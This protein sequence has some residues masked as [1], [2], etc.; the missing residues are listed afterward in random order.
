MTSMAL[1]GAIAFS[2]FALV[3]AVFLA[4]CWF[5][6]LYGDLA[7][8][9]LLPKE[10]LHVGSM[11]ALVAVAILIGMK[12]LAGVDP[13][14]LMIPAYGIGL[15]ALW[16]AW[17]VVARDR[18]RAAA[19]LVD[20]GRAEPKGMI[21]VSVFAVLA[22]GAA[23]LAIVQRDLF[24][25]LQAVFFASSAAMSYLISKMHTVFTEEGIYTP[26]GFLAWTQVEAYRWTGGTGESH[27]LVL[28][29]KHRIFKTK[30][31]RVPWHAFDD[32]SDVLEEQ[33]GKLLLEH[34]G[35]GIPRKREK[36]A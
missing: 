9:W 4:R 31:L 20:L 1:W 30:I 34:A 26:N 33:V 2:A 36:S 29:I 16:G 25:I 15:G 8:H 14:L 12:V 24:L 23:G 19:V 28:R 35:T 5:E 18:A 17:Y 7:V 22:L 10:I 3:V 11:M 6:E 21:A 32:V 13:D 27:T